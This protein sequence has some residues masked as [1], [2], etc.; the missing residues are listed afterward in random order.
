MALVSLGRLFEYE[1]PD[2][3]ATAVRIAPKPGS[4]EVVVAFVEHAVKHL[5]GAM[6]W[7]A[8]G[9]VLTTMGAASCENNQLNQ[10]LLKCAADMGAR[11]AREIAK[12]SDEEDTAGKPPA[13]ENAQ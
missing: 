9:A 1:T 10:E 8:V 5:P 13:T 4:L 11:L 7:V 6:D 12:A 2:D 3:G